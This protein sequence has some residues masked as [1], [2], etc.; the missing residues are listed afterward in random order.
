MSPAGLAQT[1]RAWRPTRRT[2]TTANAVMRQVSRTTS[3]PRRAGAVWERPM[4]STGN[5]RDF[6]GSRA[7]MRRGA[8]SPI[9]NRGQEP[10]CPRGEQGL[11]RGRRAAARL[12]S[13]PEKKPTT[14]A[15]WSRIATR[16]RW[17]AE[18]LITSLAV[19]DGA[20]RRPA[21][22]RVAGADLSL[23]SSLAD[24]ITHLK[25]GE[26]GYAGAGVPMPATTSPIPRRAQR[27]S[28]WSTPIRG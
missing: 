11:H 18:V 21:D 28:R 16:G 9:W 23:Q 19:P 17:A 2:A 14:S 27:P 20:T 15:C 22:R 7:T 5:D 3:A 24:E 4:R 26:T 6:A 8:T 13:P 1:L 12:R 10:R 25:V